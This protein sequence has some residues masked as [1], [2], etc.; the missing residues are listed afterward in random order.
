MMKDKEP[1]QEVD[2]CELLKHALERLQ[3]ELPPLIR[4]LI[5]QKILLE[6][7][8]QSLQRVPQIVRDEYTL[9]FW[10]EYGRQPR[11]GA[12]LLA[13]LQCK[14]EAEQ[15]KERQRKEEEQ[16]RQQKEEARW[17]EQQAR[18]QATEPEVDK[19]REWVKKTFDRACQRLSGAKP[20]RVTALQ[21][22]SSRF[23]YLSP[24]LKAQPWEWGHP[25][26]N[27]QPAPVDLDEVMA[28]AFSTE[29]QEVLSVGQKLSWAVSV[30]VASYLLAEEVSCLS[31]DSDIYTVIAVE[32][33]IKELFDHEFDGITWTFSYPPHRLGWLWYVMPET[34]T[35]PGPTIP[36]FLLDGL[37]RGDMEPAGAKITRR[38][39]PWTRY[40]ARLD[41]ELE[42]HDAFVGFL[43]SLEPPWY[44]TLQNLGIIDEA[45]AE[46][47]RRKLSTA[48]AALRSAP[49]LFT[50]E[51]FVEVVTSPSI[52][53]SKAK[54]RELYQE[55]PHN[56]PLEEAV[57]QILANRA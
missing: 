27:P 6:R 4:P 10:Y 36:L 54:A 18:R 1:Q 50:E 13:Y 43:G 45:T 19:Y 57:K 35:E 16:A 33:L 56:I 51:D 24:I 31:L 52:G 39:P 21:S 53:M 23:P 9:H 7:A 44:T 38:S 40:Y 46:I 14:L 29:E 30:P 28:S 42:L 15:L 47:I 25:F 3:K 48:P 55:I 12:E 49:D 26:A 41:V 22:L 32:V 20:N 5:A 37:A 17:Q 11:N 8:E 2:G 34:M